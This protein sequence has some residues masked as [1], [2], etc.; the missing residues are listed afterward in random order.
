MGFYTYS[1]L[2]SLT[3]AASAKSSCGHAGT[4][5][6]DSA[7]AAFAKEAVNLCV[8]DP[9]ALSPGRKQLQVAFAAPA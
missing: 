4:L 3:K 5:K 6:E 1:T 2:T 8:Y 7:E 9:T